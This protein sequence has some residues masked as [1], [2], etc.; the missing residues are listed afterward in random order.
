MS[1]S[2]VWKAIVN[3]GAMGAALQRIERNQKVMVDAIQSLKEAAA[4][5]EAD[6]A[7]AVTRDLD[8]AAKLEAALA[9]PGIDTAAVQEVA[10]EL[11]AR[12]AEA[13]TTLNPPPANP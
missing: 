2:S 3:L 13:E 10:D 12:A 1:F 5:I 11:N 6:L 9:Q 4:R 7:A 8:L